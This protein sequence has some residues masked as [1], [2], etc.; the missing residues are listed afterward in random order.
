VVIYR[1]QVLAEGNLYEIRRLI[2][3]HPHRIRVE[4]D[5]PR[6]L[7]GPGRRR[8]RPTHVDRAQGGGD[9]DR[10]SPTAA[11]TS[12]HRDARQRLELR[13]MTS[14]DNNLGAVFEYLTGD[15]GRARASE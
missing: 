14:P 9:R 10:A 15:R 3:H 13:G 5:R 2:D 6:E 7:A 11:T 1:G 12:G 4:C 8:A